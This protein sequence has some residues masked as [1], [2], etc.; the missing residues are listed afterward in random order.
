[1]SK[2][3]LKPGGKII[4]EL[5]GHPLLANSNSVNLSFYL[6]HYYAHISKQV[7]EYIFSLKKYM[8]SWV[9]VL[10]NQLTSAILQ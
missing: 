8:E 9:A 7:L 1:M 2:P 5:P 4:K 6:N 3:D 10:I